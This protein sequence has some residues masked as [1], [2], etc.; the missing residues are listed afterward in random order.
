MRRCLLFSILLL[1][2]CGQTNVA[3]APVYQHIQGRDDAPSTG[4]IIRRPVY[5]ARIP[6]SWIRKDPQAKESI[7][8][9]MR[10]LVEFL[11]PTPQGEVRLTVHNFPYDHMEERIPPAAQIARWR[12][13][14][15]LEDPLNTRE[16]FRAHDG[17]AGICLEGDGLI[18]WAMQ[19]CPEHFR[20]L[21]QPGPPEQT[22]YLRQLRADY[23]IKA[24]GPEEAIHYAKTEL[25]NFSDSFQ[26]IQEIPTPL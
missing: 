22:R 11:I 9:T 7:A 5:R 24:T 18:A 25:I 14:A 16:D 21:Q 6:D 1:V 19:L 12:Q 4:Q 26:L 10:P 23:T 20:C 13:Q 17:F 2:S 15:N 8:D 3:P